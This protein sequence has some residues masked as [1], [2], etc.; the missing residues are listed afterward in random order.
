MTQDH[1]CWANPKRKR[2]LYER[3]FGEHA[4][5][6]RGLSCANCVRPPPS[7]PAH[8]RSRGAGGD[9]RHLIPLCRRCHRLLDEAKL[10]DKEEALRVAAGYWRASPHHEDLSPCATDADAV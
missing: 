2:R 10:W 7:D 3:N 1:G 4:G 6:I 8:A 5:W 9:R